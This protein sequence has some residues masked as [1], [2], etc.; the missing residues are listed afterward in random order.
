MTDAT[1]SSRETERAVE[2]HRCAE[3]AVRGISVGKRLL[4]VLGSL[5]GLVLLSP[6]FALIALA[7]IVDS[8]G[9]VIFRQR[10]IGL[11]GRP[12]DMLKFRTMYAGNDPGAHRAYV[13]RLILQGTDDLRNGQ[14]CYKLEDDSRITRVGAWLRRFS[15]DEFPQLINVLAGEMS[16]VGPRPPLEYE[17]ELYSP[18]HCR[19]LEVV[20]GMTGLWQVSG[21]NETTFEEMIDLDLEYI[22]R[23]SV[24]L[25]LSILARTV[26]VRVLRGGA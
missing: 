3:I 9:G 22:E 6:A 26:S 19:R 14:G 4:D 11:G 18:R 23:R 13:S 7:I 24:L 10:R 8:P 21:R 20:P 2:S 5:A 25:D 15:I 12:F 1:I 17:Y 16:L